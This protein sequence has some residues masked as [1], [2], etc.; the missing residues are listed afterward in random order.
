MSYSR[1]QVILRDGQ[2][3]AGKVEQREFTIVTSFGKIILKK[4]KI[5]HIHFKRPDGSGYPPT[6]EIKTVNG[7][8]LYG[9]IVSPKIINFV[10]ATSGQSFKIH[11]DKI[12]TLMFLGSLDHDAKNYPQ[13]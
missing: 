11:R 12:N 1:D 5:V 8:D 2:A 6:D 7:D 4:N 13:F 9:K 10:L 3:G